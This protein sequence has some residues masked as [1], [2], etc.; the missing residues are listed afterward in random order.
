M[1]EKLA[2]GRSVHAEFEQPIGPAKLPPGTYRKKHFLTE[3]WFS[4]CGSS[5]WKRVR[6]ADY[7]VVPQTCWI[8]TAGMGQPSVCEQT[9]LVIPTQLNQRTAGLEPCFP[10][11]RV[12]KQHSG[13]LVVHAPLFEEQGTLE[14]WLPNT[15]AH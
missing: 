10:S 1:K 2:P 12:Q 8:R 14:Q 6:H 15:A 4:V 7:Q 11:F 5:T 3:Q 13:T 9:L